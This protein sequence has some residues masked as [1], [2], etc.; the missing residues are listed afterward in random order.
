MDN[1]LVLPFGDAPSCQVFRF[2]PKAKSPHLLRAWMTKGRDLSLRV[3]FFLNQF[4][5]SMAR[6][7]PHAQSPFKNFLLVITG[8]N[9][10]RAMDCDEPQ[11]FCSGDEIS[12][13]PAPTANRFL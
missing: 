4:P 13:S 7:C 2:S 12:S 5:F 3:K 11:L 6:E 10:M 9:K 8:S 1:A